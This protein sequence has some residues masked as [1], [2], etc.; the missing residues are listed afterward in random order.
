MM[1]SHVM[2]FFL[3]TKV[4]GGETFVTKK[5]TRGLSRINYGLEKCI[6]MGNLEAKRDWG[7]AK[8]FVYMQWLMLQQEKPSDYVIATGQMHSVR[9]FIEL[10]AKHLGW[11]KQEGEQ[12]IIWEKTGL[13][14]VGKRADTKEVVIRVDP[15]YFRPTEVDQLQGDPS[16]ARKELNWKPTITLNQIVAEMIEEDSNEAKKESLLKKER[17]FNI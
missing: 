11:N 13:D 3:T 16:K 7:H 14:E 12:A 6:Y 2:E 10:S 5:I 17:F 15:R 1:F 9:E 8:D 4:P